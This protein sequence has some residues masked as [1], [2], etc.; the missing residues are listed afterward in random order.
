MI[1]YLITIF[2]FLQNSAL[3]SQ[4]GKFNPEHL[5]T[6]FKSYKESLMPQDSLKKEMLLQLIDKWA[7]NPDSTTPIKALYKISEGCNVYGFSFSEIHY[8]SIERG[9]ESYFRH[10]YNYNDS[11]AIIEN[12]ELFELIH[13]GFL[14]PEYPFQ[15]QKDKIVDAIKHYELKEDQ[16]IADIGAGMG[17]FA[18]LIGLTDL[19]LKIY[20]TEL[21]NYAYKHLKS[22]LKDNLGMDIRCK[23]F[24]VKGKEKSCELPEKVD[25]I[26]LR[27]TLHH[28][29]NKKRMMKSIKKMLKD[30]GQLYILETEYSN[31]KCELSLR[32]ETIKSIIEKRG[33]RIDKEIIGEST[34][35]LICSKK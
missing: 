1:K 12:F 30:D 33:F 11:I 3:V 35:L 18:L 23:Y 4:E 25:K 15:I 9:H 10:G 14:K 31:S 22:K 8:S 32:S 34:Y 2:L 13:S 7:S 28:F 16:T 27:N 6:N 5:L 29:S 20:V 26:I 21:S 24:T 19:D 17:E